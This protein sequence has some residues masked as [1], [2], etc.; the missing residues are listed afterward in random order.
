MSPHVHTYTV[1][2]SLSHRC[3]Q[4]LSSHVSPVTSLVFSADGR[5]L[6][7][8][9]RDQVLV[10]WDYVRGIVKKTVPVFEVQL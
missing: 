4:V 9:G 1:C 8:G 10:C 5:T 6:I 2:V 7:S 3:V